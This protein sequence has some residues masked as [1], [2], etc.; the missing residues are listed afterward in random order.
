MLKHPLCQIVKRKWNIFGI[1]FYCLYRSTGRQGVNNNVQNKTNNNVSPIFNMSL[2]ETACGLVTSQRPNSNVTL[3]YRWDEFCVRVVLRAAEV[4]RNSFYFWK[5]LFLICFHEENLSVFFPLATDRW[6]LGIW[7]KKLLL[8]AICIR[9]YV[10]GHTLFVTI[11]I[12]NYCFWSCWVYEQLHPSQYLLLQHEIDCI[13]YL[14][15]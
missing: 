12:Q 15:T 8:R 1:K 11:V 9:Y 4:K 3:P 14:Y 10:F 7:I 2:N 13:H 5:H 6:L